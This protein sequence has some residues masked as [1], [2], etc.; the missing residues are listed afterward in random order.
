MDGF[1]SSE[2]IRKS[3][4]DSAEGSSG[5]HNTSKVKNI[6][7]KIS[8]DQVPLPVSVVSAEELQKL[9]DRLSKTHSDSVNEISHSLNK[10][11]GKDRDIKNSEK[12][13]RELDAKKRK[14]EDRIILKEQR[15]KEK[16]YQDKHLQ[17]LE[18]HSKSLKLDQKLRKEDRS[19]SQR[20]YDGMMRRREEGKG[21]VLGTIGG[22]IS[23]TFK[24]ITGRGRD[25]VRSKFRESGIG[26]IGQTFG[27]IEG[28]ESRRLQDEREREQNRSISESYKEEDLEL[29]KSIIHARRG[30]REGDLPGSPSDPESPDDIVS[31]KREEFKE[32]RLG[33]F[34]E[35]ALHRYDK[36]YGSRRDYDQTPRGILENLADVISKLPEGFESLTKSL[37]DGILKEKL[38]EILRPMSILKEKATTKGSLFTHDVRLVDSM[39]DL[40]AKWGVFLDILRSKSGLRVSDESSHKLLEKKEEH[41]EASKNEQEST[42]ELFERIADPRGHE[43]LS[44]DIKKGG[45]MIDALSG[46]KDKS[47]DSGGIIGR[48]IQTA[49]KKAGLK[50]L[51]ATVTKLGIAAKKVAAG[52]AKATVVA[53]KVATAG[54]AIGAATGSIYAA[55][56]S[57]KISKMRE[58]NREKSRE[59][60]RE[61]GRVEGDLAKSVA[62]RD[63]STFSEGDLKRAARSGLHEDFI[64]R[65]MSDMEVKSVEHQSKMELGR[66]GQRLSDLESLKE[67]HEKSWAHERVLD[68]ELRSVDME[69]LEEEI[70][71]A[72]QQKEFQT[73]VYEGWEKE[74]I[75]RESIIDQTDDLVRDDVE[76]VRD[77]NLVEMFK[78][79][80]SGNLVAEKLDGLTNFLKKVMGDASTDFRTMINEKSNI[81]HT[82]QNSFGP[83]SVSE[84]IH[85]E[86]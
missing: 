2:S 54:A 61:R 84:T 73:K 50:K 22:G 53:A 69:K 70:R 29:K 21:G 45:G 72:K 5:I 57:F 38:E 55:V 56:E 30:Y 32:R 33:E 58:E 36:E 3:K 12:R 17:Y 62:E 75:K 31:R 83:M 64:E 48:L 18:T 82:L 11:L 34:G 47:V 39:G 52:V 63:D 19:I 9:L 26:K 35:E 59:I 27:L 41:L 44:I 16:E 43:S 24:A 42:G 8:E 80:D 78:D 66:T 6:V 74:R 4:T 28:K 1:N 77:S 86:A 67:R 85:A 81:V 15:D 40:N 68:P 37:E 13:R 60:E 76:L 71:V 25:S 20:I 23:E 49:M 51:A 79:I 65:G 10:E 14:D 7:L 46:E